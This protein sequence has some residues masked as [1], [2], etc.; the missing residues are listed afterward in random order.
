MAKYNEILEEML[1]LAGVPL[2]EQDK[3]E[4]EE[5][6]EVDQ[7]EA[8][9]PEPEPEPE[10]EEPAPKKEEPKDKK[11]EEE[12]HDEWEKKI[13]TGSTFKVQIHENY[14]YVWYRNKKSQKIAIPPKLREHREVISS[15][16]ESIF[17]HI[18][19]VS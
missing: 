3:E 12:L 4:A 5:E 9:E 19:K 17:D 7:P 6:P 10:A 18:E 2:T 16:L 1:D 8:E 11:P 13:R 14:L 15:F